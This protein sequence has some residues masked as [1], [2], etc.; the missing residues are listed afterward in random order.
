MAAAIITT[1]RHSRSAVDPKFTTREKNTT[2]M[3]ISNNSAVMMY[4]NT[5]PD[6]MSRRS[7]TESMKSARPALKRDAPS[8]LSRNHRKRGTRGS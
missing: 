2:A 1:S 3:M 7:A 6:R 5:D 8:A 4:R